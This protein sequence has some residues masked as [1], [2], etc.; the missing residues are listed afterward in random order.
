MWCLRWKKF[1]IYT[2]I[3]SD[4]VVGKNNNREISGAYII[5]D[6]C[7]VAKHDFEALEKASKEYNIEFSDL[8]AVEIK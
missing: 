6:D 3:F 7:V 8:M 1:L 5:I 2:W 4:I